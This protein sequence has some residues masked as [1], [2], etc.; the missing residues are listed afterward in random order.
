MVHD[1]MNS[2]NW[3]YSLRTLWTPNFIVNCTVLLHW[4]FKWRWLYPWLL[5]AG[6]CYSTRDLYFL[7]A[8]ICDV[9]C[10]WLISRGIWP[11]GLPDLGSPDF[12]LWGA[13]KASVYK[14]NPH[15]LS[16]FKEAISNFIRNI[17]HAELKHVLT[18]SIKTVDTSLQVYGS[19]FQHFL[20]P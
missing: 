19:H 14:D 6:W 20:Q 16:L 1:I 17:P 3:S 13:M 12:Y 11:L 8:C 9:F 10:E 5:P 18:N 7:G 15:S 4:P 2:N